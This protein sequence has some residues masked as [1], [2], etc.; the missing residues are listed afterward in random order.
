MPPLA[1]EAPCQLFMGR[2]LCTRWNLLQTDLEQTMM[3][4]LASR[5][6]NH[7]K[8]TKPQEFATGKTVMA[9]NP[10]PGYPAVAA[11]VKKCLGPL[12]CLVETQSGKLW[13]CH[14]NHLGSVGTKETPSFETDL[15]EQESDDVEMLPTAPA[16]SLTCTV[17]PDTT[18]VV[19]GRGYPQCEHRPPLSYP[20]VTG[21]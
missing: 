17:P 9:S 4:K 12:T 20:E 7:D 11:V 21:D 15:E 6:D 16:E 5:K 18:P 10:K 14:N 19:T 1:N 13:K 3:A 2:M 8:H